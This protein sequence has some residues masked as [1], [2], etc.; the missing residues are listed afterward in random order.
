MA[1]LCKKQFVKMQR[2]S[3]NKTMRIRALVEYAA[4]TLAVNPNMREAAEDVVNDL[5]FIN[6]IE[7][8]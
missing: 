7:E 4:K 2:E 6:L 5:T 3:E 8:L 1:L